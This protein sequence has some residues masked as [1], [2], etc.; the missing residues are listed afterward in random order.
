MFNL[1]QRAWNNVIIFAMLFMVYLFSISNKFIVE[2]SDDE[3]MQYLLPEH[4][5]IMR[6]QFAEVTLERIGRSWRSEGSDK[7]PMERLQS[8]VY[9]WQQLIVKKQALTVLKNPYIVT[10]LL[11]G[12][13]KPRIFQIEP[14]E[15]GIVITSGGESMF[16]AGVQLNELVPI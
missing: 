16:A 7:W 4:S 3:Q 9:Q 1:S 10:V 8:S 6:I 5:V 13:E 12:E 2:N 11:A 15:E 14:F